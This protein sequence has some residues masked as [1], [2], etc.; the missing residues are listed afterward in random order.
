VIFNVYPDYPED[1]GVLPC[2]GV[3]RAGSIQPCKLG[4]T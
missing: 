3:T 2:A 4:K 1:G